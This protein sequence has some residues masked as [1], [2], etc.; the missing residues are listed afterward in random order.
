MKENIDKLLSNIAIMEPPAGLQDKLALA[1]Q[2]NRKLTIKLGFDPT[3][4]DLHLGHSVVLRKLKDFQDVGHRIVVIIGDFTAGIGDPTGRNK[5]R[6]PLTP[7]QIHENSQTYINQL[8][9]VVNIENIEI[10]KNSEWFSN[11]PFSDVIKLISK[12]TLA[13]IM[14]RDDFKTRFESKAPVHLHEIIYPILQGYDSVMIDSDI[15]L[16]GT[17]QLFNNLVGRTLQEAYEKKG[18]VVI[19]MPLLEGLDGTE[20]MSKSKNNYIGL[21]DNANDM[22]GKVMSIPD[23]VIINYLTLATDMEVEKQ[24]AIVSQLKLGINPMKVK[25]D[26]AYNIVKRY[27]DD[28][29]AKEAAEHFERVIQKRTPEEADH[30]V[31]ILPEGSYITLLDLCSVAL[32]MISRSE[33]RRLI[34]SGAVRIDKNKENNE[35]KK[36][37]V[38]P[39]TLIWIGKRYKFRIGS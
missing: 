30:G 24:S 36:I 29:S 18:Q 39:G 33:L 34:R 12:I 1:R 5:L 37:E 20:K 14:H 13:Q 15:E 9:K 6:P 32:P 25:K 38:I 23:S 7:E 35:I 16:G 11:M 10:R 31:L 3:A 19:T 17:D 8:A 21:T 27:H 26:I 4:P 2:E 22:Y 28:I